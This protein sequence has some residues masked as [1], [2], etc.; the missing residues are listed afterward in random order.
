MPIPPSIIERVETFGRN[1]ES[2]LQPE[3]KET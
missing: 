2:Y 1:E 3:Y